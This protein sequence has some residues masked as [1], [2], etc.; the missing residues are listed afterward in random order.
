MSVSRRLGKAVVVLALLG[1]GAGLAAFL[2]LSLR[3]GEGVRAAAAAAMQHH[4]GERV[5]ALICY[6]EDPNHRLQ[7][8]NRAVW[9]LGQLGDRR[10]LP[11]LRKRYAGGPC[12]HATAL[13]QRELGKAIRLLEGGV[14]ATALVWRRSVER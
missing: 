9:A 7:D 2:L 8:R 10:A 1:L 3:I 13:C 14:N 11:T 6:V 12:D 5:E 4:P